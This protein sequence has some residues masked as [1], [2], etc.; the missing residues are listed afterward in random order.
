MLA[1]LFGLPRP[2]GDLDYLA[3]LSNDDINLIER[4]AGRE[5][6]LAKK[7]KLFF[8][9]VTVADLPQDYEK[10]LQEIRPG[11]FSKLR[12][13]ALEAHDLVL[14]KL[15]RNSSVDDAD[16]RFLIRQGALNPSILRQRYER[17]LRPS[18]SNTKRHDLTLQL[19]L[20]YFAENS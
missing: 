4:I 3:V 15:T 17:E 12:L 10:R 9:P 14:S 18:L 20:E 7:Y 6:N 5:S 19:W 1:V 16:V 13:L 2:T 11:Q 8:Q